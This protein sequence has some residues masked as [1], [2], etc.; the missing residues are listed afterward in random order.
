MYHL[1]KF[2]LFYHLYESKLQKSNMRLRMILT[3]QLDSAMVKCMVVGG[4]KFKSSKSDKFYLDKY[5]CLSHH[6]SL[7]S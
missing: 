5:A 4:R 7:G 3:K 2:K 1:I 6:W